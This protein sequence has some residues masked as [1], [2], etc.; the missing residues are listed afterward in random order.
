MK[1]IIS[2]TYNK[3]ETLGTLLLMDGERP[4]YRCKTIELPWNNNQKNYSCIPEGEYVVIRHQSPSKGECFKV[5]DVPD[6]TDI[7]I[8]IGNFAA[9][10][11]IDTMGCILPGIYFQD[12]NDDGNIDIAES[13]KAMK[14]LLEYSPDNFTLIVL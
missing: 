6:R 2:R 12:I 1:A 5:L 9:G 3:N 11:K 13:T 14:Y 4:I 7:L 8:H 10:K